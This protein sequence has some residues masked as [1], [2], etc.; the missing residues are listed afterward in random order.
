MSM[1]KSILEYKLCF[2]ESLISHK[3]FPLLDVVDINVIKT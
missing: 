2:L 1:I 3:E